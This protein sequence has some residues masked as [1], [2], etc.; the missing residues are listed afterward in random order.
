MA[1]TIRNGIRGKRCPACRNWKPLTEFPPDPSK[2]SSQGGRHC[3]CRACHRKADRKRRS[4]VQ[5]LLQSDRL[6]E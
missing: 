3:H 4:I 2:G 5:K 6:S 1:V